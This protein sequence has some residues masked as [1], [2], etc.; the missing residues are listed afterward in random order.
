MLLGSLAGISIS[1]LLI[2]GIVPGLILA[3]LFVGYIILR[4][5]INP[6]LAPNE[7]LL[8]AQGVWER[9]QAVHHARRCRWSRSSSS[10]SAP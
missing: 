1:G 6:S 7:E 4:A 2:G 8:P 5:V 3:S 9:W 10:W